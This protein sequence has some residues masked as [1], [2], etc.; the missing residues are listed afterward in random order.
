MMLRG[1]CAILILLP[2]AA[3][4]DPI[5]VR[6]GEHDS[7]TRLTIPLPQRVPWR[8]TRRNRVVDLSLQG[9]TA[10]LDTSAVFSRISGTRLAGI[11]AS[12]TG[13]RLDLACECEVSGFWHGGTLLVVD[14][15]DAVTQTAVRPDTASV[16]YDPYTPPASAA[17][18]LTI[19][20][21]PVNPAQPPRE[22]AATPEGF[23][24]E[25]LD[26]MRDTLLVQLGRAASQGLLE[27]RKSGIIETSNPPPA[28]LE[29]PSQTPVSQ[30]AIH[31]INLRAETSMD[32]EFVKLIEENLP[33]LPTPNCIPD[34][35]LNIREWAD[36]RPIWSQIGPLRAN[37]TSETDKINPNA[38]LDLAR[39]YIHFGFGAEAIAV[40]NT[41]QI[42]S[43][44]ALLLRDLA[45]ILDRG[46]V[47]APN[48]LSDQIS[49]PGAAALWSALAVPN[50]PMD[51]PI[52]KDAI[53]LAFASMPYHLRVYL[54]SGLALRFTRAED[55]DSAQKILSMIERGPLPVP[56]PARLA[57]AELNLASGLDEA[58]QA[59]LA[60]V[61]ES[62]SEPSADALIRIV[63][64]H[65]DTGQ[66]LSF[67]TAQLVTAYATENRD[68]P[69]AGDLAWAQV[70]ALSASH[71]FD[72]AFENL[73]TLEA[74]LPPER[75]A[76]RSILASQLTEHGDDVVFLRHVLAGDLGPPSTLSATSANAL[77]D[78]LLSLGFPDPARSLIAA[79]ASDAAAE[80][81]RQLLRARAA[82]ALGRPRQAEVD[83]LNRTDKAANS[84][85]ARARSMVGEHG[86]ASEYY[87]SAD[88]QAEALTEAWMAENWPDL[89]ESANAEVSDLANL[90]TMEGTTPDLAIDQG[91]LARNRA[92]LENSDR[93]RRTVSALLDA[94][95]PPA[96]TEN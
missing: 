91:V 17:A 47:P 68:S 92:L 14:I 72:E 13:L 22:I 95:Q 58:A 27:P 83:L 12:E 4:S 53:L 18:A 94:K 61:A 42:T 8:V 21:M 82:L 34:H 86:A 52:D 81:E 49:C 26:E 24:A 38:A 69:L 66:T 16:S 77:A 36:D 74:L 60:E 33:G 46:S 5:T 1:L 3:L 96:L 45:T 79:P 19:R 43:P 40:L 87:A 30:A 41:S 39:V 48:L 20:K 29:T 32:R 85:R 57:R 80:R 25:A 6:S 10:T 7:F 89:R 93:M 64:T 28:P 35:Q 56:P 15:Q 37:L 2:A 90:M 62:N 51:Q 50:L 31:N 11:T 9:L 88:Q 75:P 73:Q 67:E 44:D 78:R 54:G 59:I 65:I 84:L 55:Q 70:A 76:I 71:A 63:E 23:E